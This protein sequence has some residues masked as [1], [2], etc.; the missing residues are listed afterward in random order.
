MGAKTG[1][2]DPTV[3]AASHLLTQLE[4]TV[5]EFSAFP[6]VLRL[7]EKHFSD[8]GL[9]VP[10]RFQDLSKQYRFYWL[11]FPLTLKPLDNSLFVKLKC[12]VG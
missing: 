5:A 9:P 8:H 10:R 7:A 12:A 1:A 6:Q 11:Q 3:E 2:A 4:Q